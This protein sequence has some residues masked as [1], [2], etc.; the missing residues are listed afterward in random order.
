ML[1]GSGITKHFEQKKLVIVKVQNNIQF[2]I[3]I[4]VC[5]NLVL[6]VITF[7]LEAKM[8]ISRKKRTSKNG[9]N[10]VLL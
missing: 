6:N 4:D 2:F 1:N 9:C 5:F 8:K 3:T 10:F 7:F